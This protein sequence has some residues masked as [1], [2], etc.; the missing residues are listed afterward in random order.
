MYRKSDLLLV[1]F[2]QR[3]DALIMLSKSFVM[4]VLVAFKKLNDLIKMCPSESHGLQLWAGV[5]DLI[6]WHLCN[7]IERLLQW[8]LFR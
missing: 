7:L 1:C 6:A 4:V 2:D 3:L 5:A 8:A